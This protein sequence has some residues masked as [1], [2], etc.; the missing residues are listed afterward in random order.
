MKI[1]N[2]ILGNIHKD[3]ELA[4]KIARTDV[5]H[6]NLDQWTA[7]K[8]RFIVI[9]DKGTECAVALKR[10]SQ[11]IEGDV[12][13]YDPA[14][15]T[16][17]IASINL[18]PV[19]VIDLGAIEKEDK[20]T[21]IQTCIELG[22]AIGNQ[23][24]PAII[25]GTKVYIPLTVDKKVMKSVL[26]THAIPGI[27]YTFEEG[28][29]VIPYLAPHEI[30]RLFGGTSQESHAH[31]HTHDAEGM[32]HVHIVDGEIITHTHSHHDHDH[33]HDHNL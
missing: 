18:N 28:K 17:I 20:L 25:K 11:L 14:T 26:D 16:A 23:H 10:N 30:R 27:T 5:E 12:L 7:Q 33:H 1:Y 2:D 9:G 29:E 22:H 24:W 15:N 3:A 31:V 32:P 6:L 8:S 21:I 13:E 4:E 19:L